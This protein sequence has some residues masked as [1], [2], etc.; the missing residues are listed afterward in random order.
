MKRRGE[1]T[2][3]ASFPQAG[4]IFFNQ[5]FFSRM[6]FLLISGPEVVRHQ[7]NKNRTGWDSLGARLLCFD[8]STRLFPP[9]PSFFPH[10]LP[11]SSAFR[12][13]PPRHLYPFET[14]PL[15]PRS[16]PTSSTPH[17]HPLPTSGRSCCLLLVVQGE[18]CFRCSYLGRERVRLGRCCRQTEGKY[19]GCEGVEGE[20][21]G[22]W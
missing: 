8:L 11:P 12:H 6:T 10:R 18:R 7:T 3:S 22:R 13:G 16:F 4:S 17:S 19:A 15:R 9:S 2:N 20:L 14:L 5:H 1:R 21:R